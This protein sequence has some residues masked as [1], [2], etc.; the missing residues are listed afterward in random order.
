MGVTLALWQKR[1]LA[2]SLFA[3]TN[4]GLNE[5]NPWA[6]KFGQFPGFSFPALYGMFHMLF[7]AS[8]AMIVMLCFSRPEAGLPSFA[9]LWMYID[10]LAILGL[11][12]ALNVTLNNLSLTLVSLF[13]NMVVKSAQP[14]PTVVFEYLLVGR[15]FTIPVVASVVCVSIGAAMAPYFQITQAK[16]G[17]ESE[18]SLLGLG[19]VIVAMLASA[20]KPV[21]CFVMMSGTST[22]PKLAPM[23][24]LFYDTSLSFCFMFVYWLISYERYASILY[25]TGTPQDAPYLDGYSSTLIGCAVILG[26]STLAFIFQLSN[27]YVVLLYGA[28]G[29]TI[30]SLGLKISIICAAAVQAGVQVRRSPLAVSAPSRSPSRRLPSLTLSRTYTDPSALSPSL[31]DSHISNRPPCLSQDPVSITGI[32]I[33]ALSISSYVY[34]SYQASVEKQQAEALAVGGDEKAG[35]PTEDTPLNMSKSSTDGGKPT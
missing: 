24:V 25:L 10:G 35:A 2:F 31:S 19:A 20:L 34:F 14:L 13:V 22:R 1:V 9:Q 3:V 16:S 21:V 17:A 29:A 5:F 32:S 33:V 7:S 30:G 27:Y 12:N 11:C 18:H 23:A 28:L 4:V 8:A 6:L 15:R 26:G